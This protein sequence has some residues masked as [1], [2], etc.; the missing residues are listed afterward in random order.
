MKSKLQAVGT[1]LVSYLA[2]IPPYVYLKSSKIA[3]GWK[4]SWDPAG[5]L[6]TVP[7]SSVGHVRGRAQ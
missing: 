6:Q 4:P 1:F 2:E 3:G 7:D 5:E